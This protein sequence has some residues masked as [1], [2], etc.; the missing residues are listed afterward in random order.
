MGQTF[1]KRTTGRP[2]QWEVAGLEWLAEPIDSGGAA[3][4]AVVS[5]D[6]SGLTEQRVTTSAPTAKAAADFG[7]GLAVTHAVD[8]MRWG[9]GPPGWSGPGYQGPNEH[10]IDLPLNGHDTWGEMYAQ[11]RLQPLLPDAGLAAADHAA[12]DR[13]CER[14]RDGDFDTGDTPSRLHGDLWSGNVL[15][16]EG[17][18]VLIDPSAHVGHRET[19]LAALGLFGFSF[20]DDVLAGY[21]E[22]VPL[23]D[24]WA[25]RVA[26]HQLS[27]ILM[28]AVVFGGGYRRQVA[29]IARRYV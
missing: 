13:L 15:W 23:A 28:H 6:E 22:A 10:L 8:G 11:E 1:T 5:R 7:R 18:C 3:V 2:A 24:G 9:Q 14:L 29:D 4:V 27:M 17:G 20:L 26:L 25:D 12:V 19:D 21:R 16:S